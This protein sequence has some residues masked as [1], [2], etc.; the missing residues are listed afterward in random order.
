MKQQVR[1]MFLKNNCSLSE[2][3]MIFFL[4]FANANHLV[5]AFVKNSLKLVK[6]VILKFDQSLK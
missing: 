4:I 5:V 6:L 2:R 1:E 3:Y